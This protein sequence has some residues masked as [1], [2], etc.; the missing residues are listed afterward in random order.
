MRSFTTTEHYDDDGCRIHLDG[1]GYV[2]DPRLTRHPLCLCKP[3]PCQQT[4]ECTSTEHV[5]DRATPWCNGAA[6]DFPEYCD[7]CWGVEHGVL[8]NALLRSRIRFT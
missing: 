6:G 8:S 1:Y 7:T 4:F 3:Q 5:G 2:V